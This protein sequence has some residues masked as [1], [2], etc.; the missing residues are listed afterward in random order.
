M[1]D[2]IRQFEVT[3]TGGFAL[4]VM[5]LLALST[6]LALVQVLKF[7]KNIIQNYGKERDLE[8]VME[9][10]GDV[11]QEQCPS[12]K[13]ELKGH[14]LLDYGD[15]EHYIYKCEECDR[16]SVWLMSHPQLELVLSDV[17]EDV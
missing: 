8:I 6:C 11:F 15:G 2:S 4:I 7:F 14:K 10:E 12:C 9:M 17:G 13:C 5:A 1:I 3:F 16:V